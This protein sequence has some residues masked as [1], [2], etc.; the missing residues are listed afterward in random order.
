MDE[1]FWERPRPPVEIAPQPWSELPDDPRY[2]VFDGAPRLFVERHHHTLCNAA[3]E[4]W[5]VVPITAVFHDNGL[6]GPQIEFGPWS[7]E[8]DDA[9]RLAASLTMLA[10]AAEPNRTDK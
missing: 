9:R 2:P 7:I 8:P 5:D 10:D 1:R 6:G 4:S 3:T